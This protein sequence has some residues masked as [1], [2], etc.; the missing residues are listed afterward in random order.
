MMYF[1]TA[2]VCGIQIRNLSVVKDL[3]DALDGLHVFT[4]LERWSQT[5]FHRHQQ[6]MV[7]NEAQCPP[8]N[9]MLHKLVDVGFVAK[10]G[11]E[12]SDIV[13]CPL[14]QWSTVGMSVG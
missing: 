6:V 14:I 8:V 9:L 1:V 13:H 5:Q 12:V 11:Q 10:G 7:S 3:F 4:D 2:Y